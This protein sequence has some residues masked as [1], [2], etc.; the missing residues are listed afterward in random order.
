M[1]TYYKMGEVPKWFKDAKK[2]AVKH[3]DKTYD[4]ER[5]AIY[6]YDAEALLRTQHSLTTE[7]LPI[8][9]RTLKKTKFRVFQGKPTFQEGRMIHAS[10]SMICLIEDPDRPYARET[11]PPWYSRVTF[12]YMSGRIDLINDS[13]SIDLPIDTDFD[14]VTDLLAE[15][16]NGIPTTLTVQG[17]RSKKKEFH[18]AFENGASPSS[19]R[20]EHYSLEENIERKILGHCDFI[21]IAEEIEHHPNDPLLIRKLIR[22]ITELFA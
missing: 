11:Y 5:T 4:I 18:I 1:L 22:H 16:G 3:W 17:L 10:C 19:G 15:T 9:E 14:L 20:G 7:M 2:L 8:I 12:D 13:L 21:D 6:L